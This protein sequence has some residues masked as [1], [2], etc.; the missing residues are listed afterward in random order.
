MYYSHQQCKFDITLHLTK[1]IVYDGDGDGN[2]D[3]DDERKEKAEFLKRTNQPS[4]CLSS[5]EGINKIKNCKE[6]RLYYIHLSVHI[7]SFEQIYIKLPNQIKLT[8]S[9]CFRLRIRKLE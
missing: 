9:K 7:A 6:Q 1:R 3:N 8:V 5:L 4:F 2:C